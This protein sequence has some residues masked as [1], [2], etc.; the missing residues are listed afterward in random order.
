MSADGLRVLAVDDEQSQLHDLARLLNASPIV[1]T[2]ECAADGIDALA[3][4]SSEA[5]DA[6]FCCYLLELLS[7]EDIVGTLGEFRNGYGTHEGIQAAKCP[8]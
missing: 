7:T 3:K 8:G 5:F 4:L 2:V 6:I 1:D